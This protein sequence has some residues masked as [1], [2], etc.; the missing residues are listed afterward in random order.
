MPLWKSP[1]EQQN[2]LKSVC[3]TENQN[4]AAQIPVCADNKCDSLGPS[5]VIAF[6]IQT[7][8]V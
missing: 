5:E 3:S 7:Q 2:T 6:N 8:S 1:P 4:A